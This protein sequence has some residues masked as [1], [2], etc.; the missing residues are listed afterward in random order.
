MTYIGIAA[1][2][3]TAG[4]I[5]KRYKGVVGQADSGLRRIILDLPRSE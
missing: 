1:W 5:D 3:G 4:E 2:R